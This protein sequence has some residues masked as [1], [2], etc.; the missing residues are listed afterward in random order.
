MN[1]DTKLLLERIDKL[2]DEVNENIAEEISK[3]HSRIDTLK[4][5]CASH[6]QITMKSKN[7]VKRLF[8]KLKS[9]DNKKE[10]WVNRALTL[11]SAIVAGIVVKFSQ[12]PMPPQTPHP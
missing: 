7:D 10:K 1:A 5:S 2:R 3:V 6:I 12:N 8:N 4:N 11:A 9:I